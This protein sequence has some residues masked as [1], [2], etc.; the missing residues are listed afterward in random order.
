MLSSR[1]YAEGDGEGEAAGDGDALA[2]EPLPLLFFVD[3]FFVE[4]EPFFV[5]EPCFELPEVLF[6]VVS[7]ELLLELVVL[8]VSV[9]VAHEVMNATPTRATMEERMVFFIGM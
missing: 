2:S 5:E 7:C 6:L 9:F 1:D 4:E 8:A 3:D